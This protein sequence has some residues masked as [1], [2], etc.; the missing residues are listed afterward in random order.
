MFNFKEKF[1]NFIVKLIIDKLE[2]E[3]LD[4]FEDK[5]VARVEENFETALQA[6]IDEV[7]QV[8]SSCETE[9]EEC[10]DH[11]TDCSEI[12][13]DCEN[14]KEGCEKEVEKCEKIKEKC[15]EIKKYIDYNFNKCNFIQKDISKFYAEI[16][17]NCK[18]VLKKLKEV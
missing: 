1:I 13:T 7:T 11:K 9:K 3:L 14:E 17:F 16:K 15:E 6:K 10:Y 2:E 4:D 18:K 12:Q 5:I 8:L